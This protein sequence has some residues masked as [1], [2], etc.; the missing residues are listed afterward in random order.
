MMRVPPHRHSADEI[1]GEVGVL[2]PWE[3]F[4]FASTLFFDFRDVTVTLPSIPPTKQYPTGKERY[5]IVMDVIDDGV[6]EDGARS[7]LFGFLFRTRSKKPD[8]GG[9]A[10]KI[11]NKGSTDAFYL[12]N[13]LR[14]IGYDANGPI[15]PSGYESGGTGIGLDHETTGAVFIPTIRVS[16][17][18]NTTPG[19]TKG[20]WIIG[21]D[22]YLDGSSPP[23][24]MSG[25]F[26]LPIVID[27]FS[28]SCFE[29]YMSS[30]TP[31]GQDVFRIFRWID[32]AAGT[33]DLL[34]AIGLQTD[35]TVQIINEVGQFNFISPDPK[36]SPRTKFNTFPSGIEITQWT[37]L[38]KSWELKFI[39]PTKNLVLVNDAGNLQLWREG[40]VYPRIVFKESEIQFGSGSANVDTIL[41]RRGA[42]QLQT[43]DEFWIY[44]RRDALN[45]IGH[46]TPRILIQPSDD[47]NLNFDLFAI[48]NIVTGYDWFYITKDGM[49]N[50]GSGTGAVDTN[51]YRSG[52]NTLKTDDFL[53]IGRG[54]RIFRYIYSKDLSDDDFIYLGSASYPYI[55]ITTRSTAAG[56]YKERLRINRGADIV[57]IEVLNANLKTKHKMF[58]DGLGF[59]RAADDAL[60]ELDNRSAT[61]QVRA[62]GLK[63]TTKATAVDTTC[64]LVGWNQGIG[65]FAYIE[66]TTVNR[67]VGAYGGTGI[68][69]DIK[70]GISQSGTPAYAY[71]SKLYGY[72]DIGLHIFT[73][74]GRTAGCIQQL[75]HLKPRVGAVG[76]DIR[77][78]GNAGPL[79]KL[80]VAAS[81]GNNKVQWFN[82]T[83][84]NVPYFILVQAGANGEKMLFNYGDNVTAEFNVFEVQKT[85]ALISWIAGGAGEGFFV[86]IR[87]ES[88]PKA[89][90]EEDRLSFGPG[91]ISDLDTFLRRVGANQLS[92]SVD[93]VLE[94]GT[95]TVRLKRV[96]AVDVVTGD[97]GFAEKK[98]VE[99]GK[100]FRVNDKIKLKVVRIDSAIKCIPTHER[101]R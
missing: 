30:D 3:S 17:D 34:F 46:S 100:S 86:Q 89:K 25:K 97:L 49:L 28:R 40:E 73:D 24:G 76:L 74:P 21:A 59:P 6:G 29:A 27:N 4:L 15:L 37:G 12:I 82:E 88:K 80:G 58:L 70:D 33:K 57:D 92:G 55:S 7:D 54:T 95:D 68:A 38:D 84:A 62:A 75:V 56:L 67:D 8:Q 90:L 13:N 26:A 22:K 5:G 64:G 61:N 11:E 72:Y 101:C 78:M 36:G 23:T 47:I 31:D 65:D 44:G 53:E 48:R 87:G 20:I 69:I 81:G 66:L 91:G 83:I 63:I 42:D 14:P 1:I 35:K 9:V 94:L 43:D 93:N 51:L 2:T 45:I 98:C 85:G 18:P 60:I 16:V 32:R 79:V 41:Y 39:S 50:W 99:C 77:D 71:Q 10:F 96:R 19:A 52:A